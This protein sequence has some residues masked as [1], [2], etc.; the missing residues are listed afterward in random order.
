M[1]RYEWITVFI[2][3]NDLCSGGLPSE[4]PPQAVADSISA[5]A[6]SLYSVCKSVFVLAIPQRF[7][8]DGQI[9]GLNL[10]Y[11]DLERHT[12]VKKISYE[13]SLECR[14]A[15]RGLTSQKSNTSFV[16]AIYPR[17]TIFTSTPRP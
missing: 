17:T 16:K 14:R 10:S 1:G 6:D 15:Y 9:S 8:T 13:K 11:D 5:L 7:A 2:G 4:V 3:G 12:T